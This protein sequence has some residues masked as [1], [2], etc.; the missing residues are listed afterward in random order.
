LAYHTP[1]GAPEISI[2]TPTYNRRDVLLRAIASVQDQGFRE[3]EHIIIDD[4]SDDGTR[5]AVVSID[6]PRLRYLSF[7]RRRG[8]NAARNH[9][10]RAAR[11]PLITFLDSD[12]RFL[13][14]RLERTVSLFS[15]RPRIDVAISSFEVTK[16]RKSA[17]AVNRSGHLDSE[18][19]ESLLIA[20]TLAIAGSAITVRK[21]ALDAIG[22]FDEGLWRLQDRDLLL[23]LA[24][25]GYGAEILG[26]I[27]W[28]KHG[29]TDSISRQRGGY[30]EAYAA[31]VTRHPRLRERYPDIVPYMVARRILSDLVQ[32]RFSVALAE[33]QANRREPSLDFSPSRLVAGYVGGRLRRRRIAREAKVL[34]SAT[35]AGETPPVSVAT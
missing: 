28:V 6:D 27:D 1:A 4:G 2:V 17:P 7:D 21:A 5:Q 3:Y 15:A 11:A 18:T 8:A 14:S 25:A 31:L 29:S 9:G 32:A 16:G 10:I 13:R 12:D 24:A 26:E 19:L 34:A 35:S 20:Q 22:G 23:R 33:M 30:V